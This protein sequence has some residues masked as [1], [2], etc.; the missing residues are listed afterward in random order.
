M[1]KIFKHLIN[2]K[3]KYIVGI[4]LIFVFSLSFYI[5]SNQDNKIEKL[6]KS[7]L[8]LNIYDTKNELSAT[9]SG[10][11]AFE[12][13]IL[14]TNY[15]VIEN[16]YKIEAVDEKDV[17]YSLDKI[18][19]YDKEK[20]LAILKFSS[21]TDLRPLKLHNSSKISKGDEVIAIGSPL[22]L[23]N[24]VSKGI[25]SSIREDFSADIIQF[26]APVSSGSSGGVLLNE[27]GKVIGVTFAGMEDGQNLNLAIPSNEILK[28][29]KGELLES[30]VQDFFFEQN[31]VEKYKQECLQVSFD[32]IYKEHGRYNEKNICVKGYV[33]SFRG[34]TFYLVDKYD[35]IT[36]DGEYDFNKWINNKDYRIVC[37][38]NKDENRNIIN[39]NL[40]IGDHVEIYGIFLDS[41]SE[42][43]E[44]FSK[45]MGGNNDWNKSFHE[46][47]AIEV[48]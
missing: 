4:L 22:G 21:P 14:I 39:E 25:V 20:D 46:A 37:I 29:Y 9:G 6:S 26:T 42:V 24:T 18:V 12:D 23:K 8:L 32:E 19:A 30:S 31:P 34:D 48:I 16:G 41:K 2:Q 1:N 43:I 11:I 7:V 47:K 13:D 5:W 28:V 17:V 38:Y 45:G 27:R 15:H 44:A 10:F 40:Q 33:S 36:Y 3:I 35:A